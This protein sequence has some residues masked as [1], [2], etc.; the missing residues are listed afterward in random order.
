[1]RKAIKSNQGKVDKIHDALEKA[2]QSDDQIGLQI[3]L[4]ISVKTRDNNFSI[5]NLLR[6]SMRPD[7]SF[8]FFTSDAFY[9]VTDALVLASEL[10]ATKCMSYL[11][12]TTPHEFRMLQRCMRAAIN[13]NQPG[14][15]KLLLDYLGKLDDQTYIKHMT[16][17]FMDKGSPVP[18]PELAIVQT[19]QNKG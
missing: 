10:G 17:V 5:A 13:N 2:V 4:D 15:L 11:L 9:L 1:M 14:A 7:C 3:A 16:K 6:E 12:I 19:H 18:I 8:D